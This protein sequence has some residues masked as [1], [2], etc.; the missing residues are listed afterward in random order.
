MAR[1]HTTDDDAWQP[2]STP[3]HINTP[4]G[5]VR[6]WNSKSVGPAL[7]QALQEHG[8]TYSDA[9]LIRRRLSMPAVSSKRLK[10]FDNTDPYIVGLASN[11]TVFANMVKAVAGAAVFAMPYVFMQMGVIGAVVTLSLLAVLAGYS[12]TLLVKAKH[13]VAEQTLDQYISYV[14]VAH[15]AF[16]C[17][18]GTL[19]YILSIIASLGVAAANLTFV[20]QTIFALLK[21]YDIDDVQPW[22]LS[23]AALLIVSPLTWLRSFKILGYA[24]IFGNMCLV[25]GVGGTLGFG[26]SEEHTMHTKN[27]TLFNIE[28]IPSSLGTASFV[29][30]VNFLFLPIERSMQQPHSFDKIMWTTLG[31]VT[32]CIQAFAFV[33]YSLFQESS[34]GNILLNLSHT[35]AGG[36][37]LKGAL[38]MSLLASFPLS[39]APACETIEQSLMPY[40][41]REGHH[42]GIKR[43]LMRQTLIFGALGLSQIKQFTTITNL[44]G[45]LS[46][47]P[48][49]LILPPA[50][51][52]KLALQSPLEPILRA[53]IN[54]DDDDDEDDNDKTDDVF[55]SDKETKAMEEAD[56][57]VALLARSQ[58][59]LESQ[60]QEAGDRIF[61]A[62][63]NYTIDAR[64]ILLDPDEEIKQAEFNSS[65]TYLIGPCL[66]LMCGVVITAVT[67]VYTF[68]QLGEPEAATPP[69]CS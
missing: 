8:N 45:A 51:Y 35:G 3:T 49:T 54:E 2:L 67:I 6:D 28:G 59:K 18:G 5:D 42:R 61:D 7:T 57:T 31:S 10:R 32:F 69:Q 63:P 47:L 29:F 40:I 58:L 17:A 53:S 65:N 55:F 36:V 56:E 22:M 9:S 52:I 39:I 37:A 26:F 68:K 46:S 48:L 15:H 24:S 33:C 50:M 34:C 11:T 20:V 1:R 12:M 62:P 23:L 60:S 19:S 25:A 21:S 44:I 14:D 41:P 43:R 66:L 64:E 4:P 38:C 16:G 13:L 30:C 27:L